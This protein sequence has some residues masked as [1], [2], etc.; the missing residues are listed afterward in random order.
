MELRAIIQS[1]A[2][3]ELQSWED[4]ERQG[5]CLPRYTGRSKRFV[6]LGKKAS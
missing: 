1:K 5:L 4:A 2:V 6:G 3:P